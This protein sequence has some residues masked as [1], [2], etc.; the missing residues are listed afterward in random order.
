DAPA[1]LAVLRERARR[2]EREAADLR[3]L[4]EQVHQQRVF[5]ALAALTKGG[6]ELIDLL[7]A[8]LLI[9]QLDNEELDVLSYRKQVD[10]LGQELSARMPKE[11]TDRAKLAAL[12]KELFEERGFHG[13]RSDYY[14]RANS[15]LNNV[16]DDR[17][18]LPITLA[19]L[20]MELAGRLGVPVEG[21]ALPGHF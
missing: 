10:R 4:A 1:S 17:E 5:A 9:A 14:Q 21:V 19:I 15:Y 3:L 13:S 6:D 7:H 8:A 12:S 16:L 18:G 20:Y 2:L 11:G